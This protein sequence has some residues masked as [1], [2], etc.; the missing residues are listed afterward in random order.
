MTG[1]P[2]DRAADLDSNAQTDLRMLCFAASFWVGAAV[3]SPAVG[4]VT[5][6]TASVIGVVVSA[7]AFDRR[8]RLVL[9]AASLFL[10]GSFVGVRADLRYRPVA[11][12]PYEGEVAVIGDPERSGAGWLIEVRLPTGERVRGRAFGQPGSTVARAAFGESLMVEGTLT[13]VVDQPWLRTRHIAGHLSIDAAQPGESAGLRHFVP[14]MVRDRI[15]AGA[16][17]MDDRRRALYLGLVMGDDRLQPLGQKLR[18]NA[19]GLTHLLAVSGQNVAFV[20]AVARP[21]LHTFGYRGRFVGLLAVLVVFAVITRLEP[22]VLRATVTAGI[23]AWASLTGRERT[24]ITVL[25][26]AAMGLI[27]IDPFLVDSVGFQ[28]SVAASAAI[29]VLGPAIEHR[30]PGPPWLAAPVSITVAAQLGVSPLLIMYF[31]PVSAASV[32]ANVLVGWAA[33]A[34][35]TLGLTVGV[36]AGLAPDAVGYVVQRPTDALLWWIDWVA[37]WQ[38]GLPAPRFGLITLTVV[39]VALMLV[40]AVDRTVHR[41]VPVL[42][43]VVVSVAAVPT[44][45]VAVAECGTGMTWYPAGADAN[46]VLVISSDAYDSSVGSCFDAGIRTVDVLVLERGSAQTARLAT[47]V[48]EVMRVGHIMAPPQHRVVGARRQLGL[49][50]LVTANVTLHVEPNADGS[51]LEVTPCCYNGA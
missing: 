25:C 11:S 26:L 13:P 50:E 23:A 1:S 19:A 5:V 6:L 10:I 24:G 49:A 51:R 27:C 12:G 22:S 20:L 48:D 17:T 18:F 14:T 7:L 9:G 41:V 16:A 37:A 36:F 2:P 8:L 40:R 46:S 29:L 47:A 33:A 31:G 4:G 42:V 21:V 35:M 28:L 43:L 34:V 30:M 3:A 39:I 44:G 32:P 15:A 38:A 45:P